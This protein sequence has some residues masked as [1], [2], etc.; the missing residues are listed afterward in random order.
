ML[1]FPEPAF[2]F[3]LAFL[4]HHWRNTFLRNWSL[5]HL[6]VF[7]LFNPPS[8]L[9]H[10]LSTIFS[11]GNFQVSERRPLWMFAP[12]SLSIRLN[13]TGCKFAKCNVQTAGLCHIL[14]GQLLVRVNCQFCLD[15]KMY[16]FRCIGKKT[17][18]RKYMIEVGVIFNLW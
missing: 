7:K 14:C 3:R 17:L 11:F 6:A 15:N 9:L 18:N 1:F 5:S 10:I 16:C 8:L 12:L 13:V 2:H 4:H